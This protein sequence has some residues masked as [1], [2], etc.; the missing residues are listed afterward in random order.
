MKSPKEQYMN[1]CKFFNGVQHDHCEQG[2]TYNTFRKPDGALRPLPC[3]KDEL[4][5][6]GCQRAVFPTEEEAEKHEREAEN[7]LAAALI[8]IA[9]G[10][11][12]ICKQAVQHRQVGHCVYGSCGHRLYQGKANPRF[13][14]PRP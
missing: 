11:C 5:G 4:A 10:R 7:A 9:E 1:W 6:E 8:G 14:D 12:P 2:V 3:F 13:T